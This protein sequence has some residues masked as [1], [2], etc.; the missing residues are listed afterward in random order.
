MPWTGTHCSVWSITEAHWRA[1]SLRPSSRAVADMWITGPPPV[2][3]VVVLVTV[4]PPVTAPP[5]DTVVTVVVE[6]VVTDGVDTG[7]RPVTVTR[8]LYAFRW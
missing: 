6:V 5:P 8:C 3:V 1:S 7:G 2:V 4:L